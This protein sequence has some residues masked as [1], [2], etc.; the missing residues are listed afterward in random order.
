MSTCLQGITEVKKPFVFPRQLALFNLDASIRRRVAITLG[1]TYGKRNRLEGHIEERFFLVFISPF[2][3]SLFGFLSPS[4]PRIPSKA[5]SMLSSRDR[6]FWYFQGA[7]TFFQKASCPRTFAGVIMSRATSQEN[8]SFQVGEPVDGCPTLQ[9]E[10]QS[11][12]SV[13]RELT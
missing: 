13:S 1:C 9:V 8:R 7:I 6:V 5:H 11:E 12:G 10:K 2:P 4:V 3:I